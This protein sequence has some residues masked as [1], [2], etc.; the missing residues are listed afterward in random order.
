MVQS[1]SPLLTVCTLVPAAAT[2]F[3][4]LLLAFVELI[5]EGIFLG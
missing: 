3:V 1:E 5:D 4:E 2:E